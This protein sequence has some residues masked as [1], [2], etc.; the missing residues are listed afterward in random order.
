MADQHI[1]ALEVRPSRFGH[2]SSSLS[3]IFPNDSILDQTYVLGSCQTP[4]LVVSEVCHRV[5]M[6][7]TPWAPRSSFAHS[8]VV[9]MDTST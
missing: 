3:L 5:S 4:S 8:V 2:Q 9:I 1:Y 6:Q 7:P